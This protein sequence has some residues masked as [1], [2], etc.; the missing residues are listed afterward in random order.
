MHPRAEAFVERAASIGMDVTVR[1][2]PEGTKTA[3]DAAAAGATTV[4][5]AKMLLY[6]GAAAFERWTGRDAPVAAMDDALRSH[7]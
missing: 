3:A 1:E 4:D 7:L 6:Q 5:G 2:F